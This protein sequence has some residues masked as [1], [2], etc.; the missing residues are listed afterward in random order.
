MELLK[1]IYKLTIGRNL[2]YL[3]KCGIGVSEK[4]FIAIISLTLLIPI[5]VSHFIPL[6]L[7][8]IFLMEVA[9]F[10]GVLGTPQLLY[11][12][13]V[14][15]FE[16]NLP[17]ALYTMILSLESGRSLMESLE[18][19]VNSGIP[20]VDVVFARV[21]LL[22]RD[23]KLSFE[24]A[25]FSVA[26]SLDSEKFKLLAGLLVEGRR[27]GGDLSDTLKTLA[28]TLED[29]EFIKG[30]LLSTTAQGLAVGIVILCLVLPA[31][32]G[33]IGG[34]SGTL[35]AMAPD[36]FPPVTEEQISKALEI[37]Q[38]GTGIFGL[39]VV[40]PL[41]GLKLNR[42]ALASGLFM[43]IGLVAFYVLYMGMQMMFSQ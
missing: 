4:A 7:K 12:S 42:M 9:Y 30:Q 5:V 21:I 37:I 14:E 29:F 8:S 41:F 28:K 13:K 34:F 20:E 6:S 31:T 15:K 10:F 33:I 16:K 22:M 3:R 25:I 36:R 38:I 24:E 17:K 27:A 19:V 39:L 1:K 26:N 11:E 23:Q 32:A 18:E 43:T 40:I 2:Y 35:S